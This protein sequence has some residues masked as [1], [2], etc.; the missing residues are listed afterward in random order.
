MS[1]ELKKGDNV[2]MHTCME[3]KHYNGKMWTCRTDQFTQGDTYKQELV[4]LKGFS[5]SFACEF[6]QIV[7]LPEE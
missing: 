1:I 7:Q 6:L 4:F 5:G 2:V 3:A